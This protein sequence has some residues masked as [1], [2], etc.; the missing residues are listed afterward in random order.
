VPSAF[1]SLVDSFLKEEYE[2]SPTLASSLGLTEYDERLDDTSAAAYER[3]QASDL[4]WLRSLP[5]GPIQVEGLTDAQFVH[6]S[7]V[8]EDDYLVS[9]RDAV[10]PLLLSS[11]ALTFFGHTHLQGGF[12]AHNDVSDVFRPSYRT[13]GQAESC[14]FPL[15]EGVRYLLNPGSVGQPRDGDW[16]AAFALYDSDDRIWVSNGMTFYT[17]KLV[18][19]V[20]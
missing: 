18:R 8:D 7:P 12:S 11:V 10:A 6:G 17:A 2:D 5:H 13:V 15:K 1:G 16:R 19:A 14:Q 20:K 3:R 9:L 4:E